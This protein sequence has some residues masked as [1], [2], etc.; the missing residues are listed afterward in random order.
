MK[1]LNIRSF[2]F[3][4]LLILAVSG[5]SNQDTKIQNVPVASIILPT[6]ILSEHFVNIINDRVCQS[7]WRELIDLYVQYHDN[8]FKRFVELKEDGKTIYVNL[9]DYLRGIIKLLPS[10]AVTLFRETYNQEFDMQYAS[11]G[12][13]GAVHKTLSKY[14]FCSKAMDL[15]DKSAQV[16]FTQ[17]SN[18]KRKIGTGESKKINKENRK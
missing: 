15:F 14:F 10:E 12:K 2:L 16:N 8:D 1:G 7:K 18:R 5:C 17:Y 13:T 6:G 11:A 3:S 9:A 4:A